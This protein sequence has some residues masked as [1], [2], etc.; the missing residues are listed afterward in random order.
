LRLSSLP[1]IWDRLK[2]KGRTGRFYFSDLPF[3]GLF[4]PDKVPIT[5]QFAQFLLDAQRG[6]LPDV[7]YID[8]NFGGSVGESPTGISQD[9]HPQADVRNGQ[10][11][12]NA[13][14]DTLRGSPQW[15]KTLLVVNYDEWGGFYDHVVPPFAPVTPEE[16]AAIGNDGRLGFRVPCYLIGPR[17]KRTHVS[18]I[19]FDHNSILNFICWRFGMDPLGAR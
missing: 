4:G 14:Y 6:N 12:L 8:P 15:D 3:I 17:A 2:D 10:V 11:F 16:S 5:G 18:H 13:V 1:T 19:P 7:A 9:D